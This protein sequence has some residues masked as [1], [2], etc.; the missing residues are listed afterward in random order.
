MHR[1]QKAK[2]EITMWEQLSTKSDTDTTEPNYDIA[3][4]VAKV[5]T[6]I[7]RQKIVSCQEDNEKGV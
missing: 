2:K 3:V 4:A 6:E 7:V 1:L 5:D